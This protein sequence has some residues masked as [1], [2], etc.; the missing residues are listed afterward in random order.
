MA[1]HFTYSVRLRVLY[2]FIISNLHFADDN[3]FAISIFIERKHSWQA[4]YW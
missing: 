4:V 1:P 3:R 2:K